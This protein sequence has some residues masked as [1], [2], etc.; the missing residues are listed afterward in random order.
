MSGFL[1]DSNLI[2]YAARPDGERIRTFIAERAPRVSEITK[3]ETLGYHSLEE[4][5]RAL[6]E[7]FFDAAI[8]LP[9]IR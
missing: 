7:R 2:I 9:N 4:T 5:E 1:L 8:I 3:V 6:L